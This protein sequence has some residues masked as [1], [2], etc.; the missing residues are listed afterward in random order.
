MRGLVEFI[1]RKTGE[2]VSI[3]AGQ[4][5]LFRSRD[6]NGD[7]QVVSV[8]YSGLELDITETYDEFCYKMKKAG[9]DIIIHEEYNPM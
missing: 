3:P 9:Y 5:T 2:P 1:N 4:V 7:I 8:K 6:E